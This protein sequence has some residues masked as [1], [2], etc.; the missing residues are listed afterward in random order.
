[1]FGMEYR[2]TPG[3]AMIAINSSY[4]YGFVFYIYLAVQLVYGA[5][6][7]S[8]LIWVLVEDLEEEDGF[9]KLKTDQGKFNME[10]EMYADI[11]KMS[12]IALDT[13]A[14]LIIPTIATEISLKDLPENPTEALF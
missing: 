1:M 5:L 6:P 8:K 3:N 7:L 4:T 12:V 2:M 10:M 14:F 9:F 13:A 11:I